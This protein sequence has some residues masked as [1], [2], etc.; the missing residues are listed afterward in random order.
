[1]APLP[2]VALDVGGATLKASRIHSGGGHK[3]AKHGAVSGGTVVTL[4]NQVATVGGSSGLQLMGK[5]LL[6]KERQRAK[7]HYVRPV[8]RYASSRGCRSFCSVFLTVRMCLSQ[9]L[10]RE[11]E[12]RERLMDAFVLE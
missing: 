11:L 5:E 1:M 4:A 12:H 8:E 9:R 10:L 6:A 2:V 3:H 7:L